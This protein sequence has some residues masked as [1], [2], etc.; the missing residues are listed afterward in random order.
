M[1]LGKFITIHYQGAPY[2]INVDH[3]VRV[4]QLQNGKALLT[5]DNK[6]LMQAD[7]TYFKLVS[8]IEN[9]TCYYVRED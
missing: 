3:I 9:I 1:T 6:D 5:L 7:E 8:E 4:A 2:F